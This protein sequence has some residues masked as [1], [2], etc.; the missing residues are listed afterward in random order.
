MRERVVELY[1]LSSS[2]TLAESMEDICSIFSSALKKVLNFDIFALLLKEGNELKI[3]ETL[4]IYE[5]GVPLLLDGEKGIVIKCANER[6]TIYVPDVSKEKAYI[7]AAEG[8]KSEVAVPIIYGDEFIGVIDVERKERNGFSPEDIEILEIFATVLAASFK[9]VELKKKLKEAEERYREIFEN[10]VMGIYRSIVGGKHL[11]VNPAL[12]KIYGYETPEELI[13]SIDDI[14][15]KLYV[16]PER[17]K[18]FID[19]L[20]KYGEV[21]EFISQVYRKDGSIIWI[22][23]NAKAV[24]KDGKIA[25]IVGTVED[26]TY[27]KKMENIRNAIYRIAEASYSSNSLYEM[28]KSIHEIIK[29]LMPADNFF[30]A[31]Y[32]ENKRKLALP[33]F[34]D[35]YGEKPDDDALMKGLTGY[36]LREG[37]TALV[38]P[39]I[40]EEMERKGEVERIS[41]PSACWLGTPLKIGEKVMGVMAVQDYEDAKAYGKEEEEIL[42]LISA[43][44]A[45]SIRRIM[46]EEALRNS[47]RKY[48]SIFENS[49]EGLY[50]INMD[51]R[52]VDVNPALE[53]FF[54]YTREELE[55]M[56]LKHLYKNPE[57]RKDF[58]EKL[59]EDGYVRNQEIEYRRKDGK[60]VIGVE[61]ATIVEEDRRKYIDGIIHDIT[62]LKEAEKEA[63]F[64]NALLRH[65]VANKLQ[66][67]VGYLELLMEEDLGEA[68]QL[69]TSAMNSCNSALEI[70]DNVRKLFI[71]KK[72]SKKEERDIEKMIDSLLKEYSSEIE[73]RK[74]KVVKNINAKKMVTNELFREAIANIIWNSIIHSG[75]N[76]IKI[77]TEEGINNFIITIEDNGK[78]INQEE[79]KKI[80]DM[81]YKGKQSKGSGL[82]LYLVQKIIEDMNGRIY[83][84][85][86]SEGKGVKFE[87][88]IPK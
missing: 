69:A 85:D 10:A 46:A 1:N 74:M 62:E 39:E 35:R 54:G 2:L 25:Y 66:L 43:Q 76:K 86:A 21:R 75:A 24:K 80:F 68:K 44:V 31:I 3:V 50:R 78:G 73:G 72:E 4:G 28:L 12:A 37:K 7:E 59:L 60:I 41:T 30:I 79:R 11:Q 48:R 84:N 9:N 14:G 5:P 67:I 56:D 32:D 38:T 81:G 49:P 16:N 71:L 65:D 29:G 45:S 26:I 18:E 77:E 13:E 8:I 88:R 40:F 33:Y 17:R 53:K 52:I 55:K 36:L 42:R 64:Y 23:E 70:I 61:Y 83:V 87:I 19:S 82:G 51:G 63:D 6:K 47:E 58:M 34:A 15:K 22:E 57:Q 27:R 20:E